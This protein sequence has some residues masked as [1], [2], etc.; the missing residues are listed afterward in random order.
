VFRLDTTGQEAHLA[1]LERVR[2][3]R[4]NEEVTRA[5]EALRRACEGTDNLMPTILN[6]VRAYATLGE[7]CNTMR[8]VF[9]EYREPVIV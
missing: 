8:Q 6:A 4:D 2:R 9:G 5:L 3:E 1:R 7:I